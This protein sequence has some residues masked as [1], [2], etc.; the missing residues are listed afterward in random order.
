MYE[1]LL[2]R[3]EARCLGCEHWKQ[4]YD[5]PWLVDVRVNG[6]ATDVVVNRA[7]YVGT[8]DGNATVYDQLIQPKYQGGIFNRTRSV[9][10][11]LTHWIYPYRGKFH[12][13]MTRALLNIVGV[14]P[15][16]LVLD[17]GRWC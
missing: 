2:A 10:Q 14:G 7:A 9:N 3:I 12:P 11:Y 16:S 4:D 1:A 15:G 8:L 17:R 13:Q 6:A 5:N